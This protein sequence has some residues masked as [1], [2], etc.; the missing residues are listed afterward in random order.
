MDGKP[1]VAFDIEEKYDE[2]DGKSIVS[3][4]QDVE[5]VVEAIRGGHTR[6]WLSSEKEMKAIAE[7]PAVILME[8]AKSR[9]L[10][11][12]QL[13]TDDSEMRRFLADPANSLWR[14]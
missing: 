8:Y 3:Y 4:T 7:I 14:I 11:Y 12:A 9:G 6:R 10:S 5:P 1:T 13:L 2:E